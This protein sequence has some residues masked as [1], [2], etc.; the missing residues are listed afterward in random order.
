MGPRNYSG[1]GSEVGIT[2][3]YLS[4]GD[5]SHHMTSSQISDDG[6]T[7]TIPG[8]LSV[9]SGITGSLFGT[10][11][12]AT[13]ALTASA[14]LVSNDAAPTSRYIPFVSNAAVGL[15]R[16]TNNLLTNANLA[17]TPANNTILATSSWAN[18]AV[19]ATSADT[20]SALSSAF[21]PS[22]ITYSGGNQAN[23]TV[24][25]ADVHSSAGWNSIG[26]G[27]Y[28]F[29]I[30]VVYNAAATTTGAKL[31]ISGST[32][33][34]YLGVDVGYTAGAGD[35][36]AYMFRTFDGGGTAASSQFASGNG[37]IM[38]GHINITSTGQLRLR[39]ASEI[40]SS[41]ITVTDVGGFLRRLY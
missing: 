34:S 14:V 26:T 30:Y 39:F 23:S 18:N 19:S 13:N 38:Q 22:F 21:A 16:P 24:T 1:L 40:A 11:S 12:W 6:T 37:A 28:Q 33:F 20:A 41:A 5:G 27:F 15:T 29:E 9:T 2:T 35:R 4:K 10:A 31:S 7:V 17:Y 3:N 25:L 32:A 36:G 8:E